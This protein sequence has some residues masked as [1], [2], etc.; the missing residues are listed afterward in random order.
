MDR[1]NIEA[2]VAT[3]QDSTEDNDASRRDFFS[4]SCFL[5]SA[6]QELPLDELRNSLACQERMS[7]PR[8]SPLLLLY[9]KEAKLANKK[10]LDRPVLVRTRAQQGGPSPATRGR[11]KRRLS[12]G[13]NDNPLFL[14]G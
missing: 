7:E 10:E 12:S 14:L 13:S 6:A 4:S 8:N 1:S 2:L 5:N 9:M 11:R 3:M